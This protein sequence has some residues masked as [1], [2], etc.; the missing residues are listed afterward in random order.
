MLETV[1]EFALDELARSGEEAAVRRAHEEY[2]RAVAE[3]AEPELRGD[4]HAAWIA[5]L[6]TELPNLR[7]VLDWSLAG[8][9]VETGLRL[10]GALHWFWWFR[11][12]IAEG[13]TWFDRARA[14]GKDPA[15]A[16]GKAAL[17]AAMLAWR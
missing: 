12:H 6:E 8:G 7:A 3:R 14:A 2:F 13:R 15:A 5:R 17:G 1:R 9:D 11:N 4:G 10:A 16:A